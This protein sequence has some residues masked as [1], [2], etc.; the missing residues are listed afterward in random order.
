MSQ[1]TSSP[2]DLPE[3]AA[4]AREAMLV[5]QLIGSG[6]TALG[7]ASF[8][9]RFGEYYTSFFG[10]SIGIER[11]AKL[12]LIADYAMENGGALPAQAV[13]RRFGHRLTELI[14]KADN[15]AAKHGIRL[16][17]AKPDDPICLEIIQC[18]DRFADASIGRY[19]NFE[20]IG[21][22]AFDPNNEPVKRWW[23]RV[24]EP[25]FARHPR[26]A[27][28]AGL[29]TNEQGEML[30]NPPTPLEFSEQAARAQQYG[31][32]YTLSVVRWLADVFDKLVD[33]AA[34]GKQMIVLYGHNVSLATY[35]VPDQVLLTRQMWP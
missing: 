17:F 1:T 31:R 15:I 2:F 26:K 4:L 25:I 6:V 10:L 29:H 28:E 14:E 3:W 16:Q 23:N 35:R 34:L 32:F 9:A 5:S 22:P 20:Q 18:L 8:D 13:V 33:E 11:L 12:I 7:R 30:T 27:V 24:V 19:A 21:N